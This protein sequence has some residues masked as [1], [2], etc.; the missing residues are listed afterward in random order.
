VGREHNTTNA[1]L[2]TLVRRDA[3]EDPREKHFGHR[4]SGRLIK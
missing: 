2:R 4:T 1:L 3:G